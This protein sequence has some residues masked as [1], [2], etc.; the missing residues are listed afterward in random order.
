MESMVSVIIPAYNVAQ[1][2]DYCIESVFCQSFSDFE[3]ILIDDGSA[4]ETAAVCKK[5][6]E[7]DRRI[8]FLSKNNEGLGPTRDMGIAMAKGKYIFFLDADDWIVPN[9]L[10]RLVDVAEETQADM[11]IFDYYLTRKSDTDEWIHQPAPRYLSLEKAGVTLKEH[12]ELLSRCGGTVWNKFQRKDFIQKN[13]IRHPSHRYEDI[14]YVYQMLTCGEKI[15]HLPELLYYYWINRPESITNKNPY[16]EE[17]FMALDE[18][19]GILKK[20]SYQESCFAHLMKYSAAY[21]QIPLQRIKPDR[22]EE[23]EKAWLAYYQRYPLAERIDQLK[24][25]LVGSES[26]KAV[27]QR[28]RFLNSE[29]EQI[30]L[31][32]VLSWN[33]N[34]WHTAFSAENY[35]CLMIDFKELESMEHEDK[36]VCQEHCRHLVEHVGTLWNNGKGVFLLETVCPDKAESRQTEE[37]VQYFIN[38]LSEACLLKGPQGE[39]E[40]REKMYWIYNRADELREVLLRYCASENRQ[41]IGYGMAEEE[42]K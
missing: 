11:V 18:I 38:R 35:D 19:Q 40:K 34:T 22:V 37:A 30:S 14:S 36:T 32:D 25:L 31:P 23:I 27:F 12:S 9:C 20:Y 21:L 15:V 29:C 4:D 13:K 5:W 41:K 8:R 10:E 26:V 17:C 28:M 42:H 7:K 24:F 39:D 1:Y 33:E 6:K 2:L 16:I 3:M